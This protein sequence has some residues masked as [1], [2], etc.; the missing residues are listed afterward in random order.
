MREPVIEKVT[1]NIGVGEGGDKLEKAVALLGKL[2]GGKPIRTKT[3]K[4]IPAFGIRPKM[5]VGAM[6]TLRGQKGID[7]L[8]SGLAALGNKLKA[9]SFDKNGNFSFG[10]KEYID[11]PKTRYDPEIG[12]FGMDVCVTVARKGFRVK[13]RRIK[14]APV[15][16]SHLIAKEESVKFIK[17]K[18]GVEVQ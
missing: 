15:G 5:F 3:M 18:F 1:V 10:I 13:R 9:G 12:V 16:A 6:V 8:K 14:P 2:T 7:F 11:I 4:R 17:D